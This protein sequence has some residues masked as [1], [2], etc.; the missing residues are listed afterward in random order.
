MVGVEHLAGLCHVQRVLGA[1]AP[2]DRD[3][4]LQIGADHAGLGT[5]AHALE[6]GELPLGLLAG[7]VG[8]LGRR[9]ALAPV[10][11][12][13]IG[14]L[15]QLPP[16]GVHLAA[17]DGLLLGALEPLGDVL[18]DTAAKV[19]LGQ[20]LALA[21]DCELQTTLDVERLQNLELGGRRNLWRIADRVGQAAGV[22]DAAQKGRHGAVVTTRARDLTHDRAVL[23][24]KVARTRARLVGVR[25][26]RDGD[27]QRLAPRR[28][29]AHLGALACLDRDAAAAVRQH[30]LV[31]DLHHAAHGRELAGDLGD[32]DEQTIV[33]L[34]RVIHR[35]R[36]GV[37]QKRCGDVHAGQEDGLLDG[38]ERKVRG[39]FEWAH[40]CVPFG[41]D[42]YGR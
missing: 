18:V 19:Q 25:A 6:P 17:E 33:V 29:G 34:Q 7:A 8:H 15:V 39:V 3:H 42:G 21:R 4:P 31:G 35:G 16:D 5:V 1:G 30:H 26:R 38:E 37:A 36:L 28:G 2:R 10:V 23:G 14:G 13:L 11:G 32:G 20:A 22:V 27:D 12:A 24:R 40:A 41:T 9:D